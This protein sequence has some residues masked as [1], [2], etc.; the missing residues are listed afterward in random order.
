MSGVPL[1]ETVGSLAGRTAGV[2]VTLETI[3]HILCQSS[4]V[5]MPYIGLLDG[6]S[7]PDLKV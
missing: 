1:V 4:V 6:S 5:E 7:I 2:K 3:R